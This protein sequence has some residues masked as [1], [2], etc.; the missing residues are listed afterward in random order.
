MARWRDGASAWGVHLQL[1]DLVVSNALLILL[2]E[3][4]PPLLLHQAL[5][6]FVFSS[7]GVQGLQ[8]FMIIATVFST[9][10]DLPMLA[11]G[12]RCRLFELSLLPLE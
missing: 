5:L 8:S 11:E 12:E 4:A 10:V 9:K 2:L 6:G 1:F 7:I 3:D